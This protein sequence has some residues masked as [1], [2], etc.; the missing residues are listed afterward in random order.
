M[1]ICSL[2]ALILEDSQVLYHRGLII[3][4]I[5]EILPL[6][7]SLP[8]FPHC[9]VSSQPIPLSL[10]FS[11]HMISLTFGFSFAL[12]PLSLLTHL[13]LLSDSLLPLYI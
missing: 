1:F 8:L 4:L 7:I 2:W 12:L 3:F 11:L 5:D 13:S 6:I 10:I 9:L